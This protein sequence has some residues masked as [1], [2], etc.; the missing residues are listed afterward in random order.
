VVFI[1]GQGGNPDKHRGQACAVAAVSGGPVTGVYNAPTVDVSSWDSVVASKIVGALSLV[2]DTAQSLSDKFTSSHLLKGQAWLA[3]K[4][5]GEEAARRVLAQKLGETNPAT[6]ALFGLLSLD[7]YKHA[8]IVAHSQGNL[9]TANALNAVIALKGTAHIRGMKVF[10]VASPTFFWG[11]SRSI[12]KFFNFRN[13]IVGWLSGNFMVQG[14]SLQYGTRG[15]VAAWHR[16]VESGRSQTVSGYKLIGTPLT[17][18]FYIY[19]A[20][21]WN[22]LEREFP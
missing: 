7:E 12:V 19:L 2:G 11:E 22:D 20:A 16:T 13:D 14:R 9:I 1:N 8:R 5:G 15:T 18:S 17:H 4:F 3:G 6:A 10:A 21:L